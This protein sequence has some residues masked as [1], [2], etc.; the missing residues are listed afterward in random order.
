[1]KTILFTLL[2]LPVF[3]SSTP[4]SMIDNTSFPGSLVPK[5]NE[6]LSLPGNGA[7]G[8][9]VHLAAVPYPLFWINEAAN[10]KLLSGNA[11]AITAAEGT[12]LYTFVDGNYYSN[13]APKL[14]FVPD[15]N[16]IF[17]AKITPAF[18]GIYDGGAILLYT[19]SLNWA[20]LLFEKL[21]E[22]TLLIGSSVISDKKTDD[23]YHLKIKQNAVWLKVAKSG[24]IF[25]FYHS[26]DGNNWNL[27][28]T[29]HYD[30]P[31][32]LKIGFYSQSPKGPECEVEFS[33]IRYRGE[34]FTDFFTG[35]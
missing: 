15:S 10:F 1:M 16:F 22:N 11:V 2:L 5:E 25:S 35:E 31:H 23:S 32:N 21:D 29:F 3:F 9:S 24:K 34:A 19:D 6:F 30:N 26:F 20:K 7:P 17:S 33:D 4:E 8:D 12:D 28:R 14:L 27:T 13:N 18:E